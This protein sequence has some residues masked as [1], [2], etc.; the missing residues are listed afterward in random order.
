[1][2]YSGTYYCCCGRLFLILLLLRLDTRKTEKDR[3]IGIDIRYSLLGVDC[4]P[5]LYGRPIPSKRDIE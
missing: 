2:Q 4:L 1:V 3:K 5:Y